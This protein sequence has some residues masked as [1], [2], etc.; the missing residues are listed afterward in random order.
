MKFKK[1]NVVIIATSFAPQNRIGAIRT[2]KIAKH[3]VSEG[4]KVTVIA[5]TINSN[6]PIDKTLNIVESDNYVN[7]GLFL[8][9]SP[10][11]N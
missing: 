4:H 3:L 7:A 11:K 5:P 10:V 6:E 9:E 8:T 1:Y 2:S